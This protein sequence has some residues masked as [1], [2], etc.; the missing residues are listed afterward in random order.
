MKWSLK[1]RTELRVFMR[2]NAG[3][4][5]V[6]VVC[7]FIYIKQSNAPFWGNYT[8]FLSALFERPP[9]DV[10]ALYC[11]LLKLRTFPYQKHIFSVE[12]A[13][14]KSIEEAKKT[15]EEFKEKFPQRVEFYEN[16]NS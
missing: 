14:I 2:R 8:V 3:W 15:W 16:Q 6:S 4:L 11:T 13:D 10:M 12:E 7:V 9:E 1:P 5:I